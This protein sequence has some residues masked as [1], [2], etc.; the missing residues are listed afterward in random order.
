MSKHTPIPSPELKRLVADRIESDEAR[1]DL[2][3]LMEQLRDSVK[4]QVGP[5]HPRVPVDSRV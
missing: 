1:E 3:K 4:V 5:R 2:L